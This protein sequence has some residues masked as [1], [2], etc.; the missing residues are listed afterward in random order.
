MSPQENDNPGDSPDGVALSELQLDVMRVLWRGEASVAEVAAAL[1]DSRGL[2]HTTVATVL[3]RLGRRGVVAAGTTAGEPGALPE[4]GVLARL[5]LPQLDLDAWQTALTGIWPGAGE[6]REP[7]VADAG[8]WLPDRL[9][10]QTERLRAGGRDFQRLQLDASRDSTLWRATVQSEEVAGRVEYRPG[11]ARN[12]GQVTARLSRLILA[13][14]ARSEVERLLDQPNSVPALDLSID[15]LRWGSRSLGR[16]ELQ[17]VNRG[18]PLRQP[19]WRLT[20]LNATVPEAR[21]TASGNWVPLGNAQGAGGG[22]QRR[23]A[24]GFQL[25][26]D[27]AGRL[28]ERLGREGTVR[29]G[30]GRL[31]GN[32]GW[33]GSPL[34][35]DLSTL[36]GQLSVDIERGQFLQIEPGAGRLLGVLSLQSLPRRLV[37][38]FRDVFSQGFAFDFFRGQG[39]IEQGVLSTRNLQ[40]KGVNAAVMMEG[41]ADLVR[42]TQDLQVFVVPEI[43]AGA[44]SL[45][46]ATV[47][48][49][50]GIGTLLAQLVLRQPLRSVTT[51]EFR[52]TG[53][54]ADPQ[55][56]KL[57]RSLAA[58]ATEPATPLQ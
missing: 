25:A 45:L 3:T 51:Q 26:V 18:A 30:Q 37:L 29:G 28:L 39:Q 4:Q 36:S 9:E 50:V 41:S 56:Q 24:I 48:P 52:V 6:A 27:D 8:A 44:A 7:A 32:V 54:W 23:T 35:P 40:M 13:R 57:D 2:A 12:P 34:S 5:Q 46:A 42:E 14:E 20:R 15:D 16:I 1:A 21:L 49:V 11:T 43:N 22:G 33:I 31:E 55:V 58:P 17:A 38:D 10:L 53:S 47:N 19:E